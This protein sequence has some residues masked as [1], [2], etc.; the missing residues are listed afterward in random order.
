MRFFE[1][2]FLEI[3]FIFQI[4]F[5]RKDST[6][7]E[8]EIQNVNQGRQLALQHPGG[9][10]LIPSYLNCTVIWCHSASFNQLIVNFY[11]AP[12]EVCDESCIPSSI[13]YK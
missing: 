4:S 7:S 8:C 3:V 10:I 12:I 13:I 2:I 9:F 5:S 11:V 1:N 6:P